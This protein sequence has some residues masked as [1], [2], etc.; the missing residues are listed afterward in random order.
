MRI[1]TDKTILLFYQ[2]YETDKFFKNDRYLKRAVRPLYNLI[3]RKQKVTGYYVWTSRL[4]KA[5]KLQGFD[6]QFNNYRLARANPDFPVCITGYEQILD[7]W[8]LPNPVLLGPGLYSHP[9]LAPDLMKDKRFKK[10]IITCEWMQELFEPYYGDTLVNWYAGIDLGEWKDVKTEP[11]SNDILIYNKIR[12][13]KEE[14]YNSLLNPII[15]HVTAQG[16]SYKII[17]YKKYD[18]KMFK[19]MLANSKAMFFLCEHET[20]GMAYQEALASNVPIMA[21]DPG[22]WLDPDREKFNYGL[23]KAT[24]VPYFSA[25]CG[26]T[27]KDFEEFQQSFNQFWSNLENYQP[28]KYVKNDLSLENSAKLYYKHYQSLI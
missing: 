4:V 9:K 21:W 23:V 28:R 2:D 1:N 10:F 11:K 5:L 19:D 8:D 14:K 20:Q 24:S 26:T 7:K 12:W 16:L 17:E 25:E 6:V 3:T 13:H 22:I 18:H 27:F 15:E